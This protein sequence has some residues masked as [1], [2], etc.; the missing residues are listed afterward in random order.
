MSGHSSE[1][2]KPVK[3]ATYYRSKGVN[4]D[5]ISVLIP[6]DDQDFSLRVAVCLLQVPGIDLHIIAR[7]RLNAMRFSRF[8]SSFHLYKHS[9][10]DPLKLEQIA[11]VVKQTGTQVILPTSLG[12]IGFVSRWQEELQKL[13]AVAFVP[14]RP[15]FEAIINKEL[16]A[17]SLKTHAIPHP[18]TISITSDDLFEKQLEEF[19]FPALIKPTF[20][21]GGAGIQVFQTRQALL[22][23]IHSHPEVNGNYLLQKFIPGQDF[24]CSVL[25]EK[26]KILAY[27]VQTATGQRADFIPLQELEI[28][29]DAPIVELATRLIAALE[30]SGVAH[31]DFRY[32]SLTHQLEVIEINPRYWGS[33]LASLVAGVNFPHLACLAALGHPFP[34]PD[35]SDTLYMGGAET[36]RRLLKTLWKGRLDWPKWQHSSLQFLLQDPVPYVVRGVFGAS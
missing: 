11:E 5:R 20:G 8:C 17:H 23:F 15:T 2:Y 32:N 22:D 25:S 28:I 6:D 34:I 21:G 1:F 7:D 16:F 13:A 10:D 12:G 29:H 27:T 3:T 33:L 18:E 35:Y 4:M 31:I 14:S 24:G 9:D 36:V 30:W 26:G 19:P